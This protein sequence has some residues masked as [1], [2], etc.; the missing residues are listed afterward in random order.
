MKKLN[1]INIALLVP[2]LAIFSG[3]VFAQQEQAVV[4][5]SPVQVEEVKNTL[6]TPTMDIVGTIFSRNNVRLTAGVSGRLDWVA[7]PGTFL[8]QDEVVARIDTLPLALQQ[9]EQRA[10]IKRAQ[11]NQEYLL[12]QREN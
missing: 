9:A 7:E 4:P 10:E 8:Q 6:F 5:P 3:L 2:V 11:I 1:R 12:C